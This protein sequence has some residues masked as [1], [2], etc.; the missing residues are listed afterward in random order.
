MNKNFI[1]HLVSLGLIDKEQK[2]TEHGINHFASYLK[3]VVSIE[4][5][6]EFEWSECHN[7]TDEEIEKWEEETN[8][9]CITGAT[10]GLLEISPC[11]DLLNEGVYG[12]NEFLVAVMIGEGMNNESVLS[13]QSREDIIKLRNYLNRFLEKQEFWLR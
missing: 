12:N 5:D 2:L 3:S 11:R 1:N 13:L 10:E 4:D 8:S 6:N 7:K 9:V